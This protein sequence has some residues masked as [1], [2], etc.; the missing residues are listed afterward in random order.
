MPS[1]PP[2]IQ[3]TQNKQDAQT[4]VQ[5]TVIGIV[6]TPVPNGQTPQTPTQIV[7]QAIDTSGYQSTTPIVAPTKPTDPF[8]VPIVPKATPTATPLTISVVVPPVIDHSAEIAQFNNP[9]TAIPVPSITL[10]ETN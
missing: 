8:V 5:Q 2:I 7:T 4:K 1:N 10:D 9:S 6:N 3:S